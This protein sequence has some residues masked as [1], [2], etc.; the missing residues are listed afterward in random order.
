MD[1]PPELHDKLRVFANG[2]GSYD[3]IGRGCGR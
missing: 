2:R 3:I 1:G